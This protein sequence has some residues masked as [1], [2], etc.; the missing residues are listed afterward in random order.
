MNYAEAIK[1]TMCFEAT[2]KGVET[3]T[4]LVQVQLQLSNLTI[5]LQDMAK[6]KVV[7]EH[8]WCTTCHSKGNQR[9]E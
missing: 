6:E 9:D 7:H 2:P 4:G 1:I 5:E 3:S 8:V